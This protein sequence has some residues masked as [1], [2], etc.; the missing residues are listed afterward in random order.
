MDCLL[1]YNISQTISAKNILSYNQ[2]LKKRGTSE[3][4]PRPNLNHR[5]YHVLFYNSVDF[6]TRVFN[7]STAKYKLTCNLTKN[8]DARSKYY[9]AFK[10]GLHSMV[11]TCPKNNSDR[12]Q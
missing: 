8:V 11:L 12:C 6:R 2:F 5:F 9:A 3:R 10:H 7:M 4:L 1:A